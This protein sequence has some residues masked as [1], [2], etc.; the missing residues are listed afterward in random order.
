MANP[1]W[2]EATADDAHSRKIK[3][4][5]FL[6]LCAPTYDKCDGFLE[7]LSRTRQPIGSWYQDPID[8]IGLHQSP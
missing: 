4:I 6:R 7:A 3:T 2:F 1:F 5:W 8:I